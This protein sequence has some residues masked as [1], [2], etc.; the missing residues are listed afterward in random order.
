MPK[1]ESAG[2]LAL[3]YYYMSSES[4]KST[5]G[6]TWNNIFLFDNDINLNEKKKFNQFSCSKCL[7]GLN[8]SSLDSAGF[9]F[10]V[11]LIVPIL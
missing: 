2:F 5:S 4:L 8:S 7:L 1:S 10:A 3:P 11:G 6:T 9:V